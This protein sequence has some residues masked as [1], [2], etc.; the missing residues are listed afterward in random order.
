MSAVTNV[1]DSFKNLGEDINTIKNNML[2]IFENPRMRFTVAI[3]FIVFFA[4][5]LYIYFNFIHPRLK[6]DYVP[7]REFVN[8]SDQ[9][10]KIVVIW[11]YTQWCPF[12]KTTYGEWTSFKNDAELAKFNVPVEFREIDCDND[13][14]FANRYNIEEYPSI[15]LVY[16]DQVSIYDAKPDR[17][18][19]MEFLKGSMP[20]DISLEKRVE[21]IFTNKESS[22]SSE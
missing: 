5:S 20:D 9:D 13:E 22:K 11:F 3:I 10:N 4:L 17:Y 7:N 14:Q 12:C 16:R 21:D 6:L 2:D 19:L 18:Q 8:N 15:R 1:L